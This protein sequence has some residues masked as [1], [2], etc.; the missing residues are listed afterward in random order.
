M[1][2]FFNFKTSIMFRKIY[3]I[4]LSGLDY[5][6]IELVEAHVDWS[7]LVISTDSARTGETKRPEKLSG[8]RFF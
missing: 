3:F 4:C 2:L 6:F 5:F 1:P 7:V 8:F